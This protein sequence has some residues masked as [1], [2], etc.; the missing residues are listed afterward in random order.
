MEDQKSTEDKIKEAA[1]TIFMKKGY[2]ATKTRDIAE[3]AG[4]NLALLNYYFRSKEKLF[5]QI[6]MESLFNF[7]K[8]LAGIFMDKHTSLEVKFE[9]IVSSY[10]DQIKKQPDIPMFILSE[11]RSN[12]QQFTSKMSQTLQLKQSV[13]YQQL[14]EHLGEEKAQQLDPV[15]VIMNLMGLTLF[16][17]V[18]KPMLEMV[19]GVQHHQFNE[20][21]E[22]R[23]ELIP[24]WIM[25]MIN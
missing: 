1:R 15:H 8:D 3:Q 11:L 10:I 2:A 23:K 16:P 19:A 7:L 4:I 14:L 12:P 9:R 18:G 17:F 24:K 21:M 22:E 20:M 6:M 5:Q 25:Q 13:L